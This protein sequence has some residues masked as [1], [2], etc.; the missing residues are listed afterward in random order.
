MMNSKSKIKVFQTKG[1][2]EINTTFVKMMQNPLSDEYALLQ[3]TKMENP[4]FTVR[5]RQINSN[6][7]KDTYTP[8]EIL[9]ATSRKMYNDHMARKEEAAQEFFVPTINFKTTVKIK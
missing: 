1:I 5:R 2:I 6:P 3:K 9:A 7:H 8:Y 4:T